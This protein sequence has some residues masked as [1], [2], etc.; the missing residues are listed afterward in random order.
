MSECPSLFPFLYES[1][2][3]LCAAESVFFALN[4]RPVR[5]E[6]ARFRWHFCLA[7]FALDELPLHS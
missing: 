7:K 4:N 1:F 2:R 3:A 6:V 5:S